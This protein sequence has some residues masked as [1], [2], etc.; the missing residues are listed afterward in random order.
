MKSHFVRIAFAFLVASVLVVGAST[1]HDVDYGP[2]GCGLGSMMIGSNPGFSQVF[3][4]TTNGTS[5]SQ[6]FGIS[7][8]TSNCSTKGGTASTR[9]FIEGN[10]EALAKDMARGQGETIVALSALA[11]CA[12][13]SAVGTVLQSQFKSVVPD[14]T[15]ADGVVSGRIVE[16]L[17]Q[18]DALACHDLS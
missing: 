9:S 16:L 3:A 5:N 12:D 15:T 18:S 14:A 1:A 8:G 6:T 11:G 7:S 10:L 17:L 2:A 4:S 13:A